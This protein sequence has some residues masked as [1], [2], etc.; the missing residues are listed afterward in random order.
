MTQRHPNDIQGIDAVKGAIPGSQ[1]LLIM[2]QSY[3]DCVWI[4]FLLPNRF[5]DYL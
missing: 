5:S 2:T 1:K 4:G 3:L